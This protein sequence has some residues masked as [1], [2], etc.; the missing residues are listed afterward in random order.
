MVN[1]ESV[2]RDELGEFMLF[3]VPRVGVVDLMLFDF[4]ERVNWDLVGSLNDTRVCLIGFVMFVF[5][6]MEVD[7]YFI[8]FVIICCVADG[9]FIYVVVVDFL[10]D[11]LL[12]DMWIEIEGKLCE[13]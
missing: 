7:F 5:V 13:L 9:S 11:L 1:S 8:C 4:N 3:A 2:V 10:D 6:G 12:A